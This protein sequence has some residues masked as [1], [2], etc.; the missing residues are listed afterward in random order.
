MS[1]YSS[2]SEQ[3]LSHHYDTKPVDDLHEGH[4]TESKEQT[5]Q[6]SERRNEVDHRHLLP[7]LI[8]CKES[9]HLHLQ[10][11]IHHMHTKG[12]RISK[13]NIDNS[14]IFLK[15]VVASSPFLK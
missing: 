15:R 13:E 8:F 12:S 10:F 11:T 7:S 2:F 4:E 5:K 3:H 6:S 1:I 14:K 9:L